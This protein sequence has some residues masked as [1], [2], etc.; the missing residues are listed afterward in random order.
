MSGSVAKS[1]RQDPTGDSL[2][3]T[4]PTRH[5]YGKQ[6][7]THLPAKG[8]FRYN[9]NH[10]PI[11]KFYKREVIADANGNPMIVTTGVVFTD[12]KDAYYKQCPAKSMKP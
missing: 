12:H 7:P 6:A 9:T 8:K 4:V 10:I 3:E 11:Q 5:R 1:R 2:P